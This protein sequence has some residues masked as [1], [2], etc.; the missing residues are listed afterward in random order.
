MSHS[1]RQQDTEISRYLV[2]QD[3][4]CN[5]V[6][7]QQGSLILNNLVVTDYGY[8]PYRAA[9][10]AAAASGARDFMVA[11]RGVAY[12]LPVNL[13]RVHCL[14]AL[15]AA[16]SALPDSAAA[17][18]RARLESVDAW[19]PLWLDAPPNIGFDPEGWPFLTPEKDWAKGLAPH[20]GRRSVHDG[21]AR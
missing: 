20:R 18:F 17:A 13:N 11:L 12:H 9:N 14:A 8:L 1:E 5:T 7:T 15:L 2:R 6:R 10:A 4:R 19:T 3:V 16:F 21:A